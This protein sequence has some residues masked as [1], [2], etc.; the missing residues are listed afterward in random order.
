M[1]ITRFGAQHNFFDFYLCLGFACFAFLLLFFIKELAV[2]HDAA[3]RWIRI[4]SYL[5]QVQ[6]GVICPVESFT[7]WHD[8]NVFTV[9]IHQANFFSPDA[10]IDSIFL[11]TTDCFFSLDYI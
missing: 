5:Y 2:I 6:T 11:F 4:G 1:M 10:F 8:A 3:N 7:K 9:L